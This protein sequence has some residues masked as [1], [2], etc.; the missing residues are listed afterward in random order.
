MLT[1]NPALADSEALEDVRSSCS[2]SGLVV[3]VYSPGRSC[4]LVEDPDADKVAPT[5]N[6]KPG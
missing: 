4:K 6:G 3:E 2:S 1:E 5:A